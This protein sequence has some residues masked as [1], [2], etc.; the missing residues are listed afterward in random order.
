MH[1]ESTKFRPSSGRPSQDGR[2]GCAAFAQVRGR[3]S[4]SRAR[5]QKDAGVDAELPVVEQRVY[6]AEKH[7]AA[8]AV[9]AP[10]IL[11][12]PDVGHL[13]RHYANPMIASWR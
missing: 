3:P 8:D 12:R 11:D 2:G 4:G 7:F 1:A 5:L 6:A 13:Q 10:A 9:N